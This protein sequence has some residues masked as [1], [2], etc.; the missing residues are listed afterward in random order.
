MY[1]YERH[2]KNKKFVYTDVDKMLMR[3]NGP[4]EPSNS[5]LGSS[6]AERRLKNEGSSK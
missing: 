4:P 1:E 2:K 3:C 5:G 6:S